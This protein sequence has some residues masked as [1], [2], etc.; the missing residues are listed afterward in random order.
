MKEWVGSPGGEWLPHCT[1]LSKD[2]G[3]GIPHS[4]SVDSVDW[5]FINFIGVSGELSK[6]KRRRCILLIQ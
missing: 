5:E 4:C 3:G 6:V 2:E 1:S